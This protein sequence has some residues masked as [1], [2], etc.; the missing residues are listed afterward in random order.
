MNILSFDDPEKG[1]KGREVMFPLVENRYRCR[2]AF[3]DHAD[4][5]AGAE[6][7]GDNFEAIVVESGDN[8]PV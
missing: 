7:A 2:T 4:F 8:V 3:E 6:K 1:K 5:V